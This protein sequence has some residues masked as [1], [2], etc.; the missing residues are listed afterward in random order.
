[1][2]KIDLCLRLL[3]QPLLLLMLLKRYRLNKIRHP[4]RRQLLDKQHLTGYYHQ[5]HH[6]Q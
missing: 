5:R 6:Q 2:D 1:M 3:R 4:H